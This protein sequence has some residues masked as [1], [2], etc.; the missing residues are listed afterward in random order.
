MVPGYSTGRPRA[1]RMG[2]DRDGRVDDFDAGSSPTR[3]STPPWR[4]VPANWACRMASPA[5]STPG[6][7][8]YQT[9]TTPS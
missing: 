7:L 5:R 3:A 6:D 9:P 4:A 1:A 2:S 8:P